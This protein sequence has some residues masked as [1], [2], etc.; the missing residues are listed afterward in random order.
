MKKIIIIILIGSLALTGCQKNTNTTKVNENSNNK[1]TVS[2]EKIENELIGKYK[3]KNP[4]IENLEFKKD[5][6]GT[7]TGL[8]DKNYTFTYSI[9]IDSKSTLN[10]LSIH[11]NELN[12]TY[13][14]KFMFYENGDL[15]IYEENGELI[16]T[17]DLYY[18]VD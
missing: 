3:Y 9:T 15:Y 4:E 11:I 10:N 6:T 1:E 18:K 13:K 2:L 12:K 8:Y 7:Y 16:F 17:Y 14:F 5:K